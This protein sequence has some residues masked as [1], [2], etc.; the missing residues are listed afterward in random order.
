MAT[1][2]TMR[3]ILSESK[4]I[5][6]IGASNKTHRAS[7]GVMQFLQSKGFRCIPISPRLAGKEL[8]GEMVYARLADIPE[9]VDMVDMFINS[10]AVGAL[11]DEAI[12]IGAKSVWMQLGV[13]NEAAATRARD[14]G[15]KVVMDHCP[16]QEWGALGLG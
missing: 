5:A 9:P 10:E 6:V 8:L 14:A 16:A 13:V 1:I 12:A 15:L 11:T 3:E 4:V 2:E 7:Y